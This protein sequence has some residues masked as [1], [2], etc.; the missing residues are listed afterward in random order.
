MCIDVPDQNINGW[1][2][3]SPLLVQA[4]CLL[5]PPGQK[6]PKMEKSEIG[7]KLETNVWK[8]PPAFPG[9]VF[10]AHLQLL[11]LLHRLKLR[12]KCQVNLVEQL[13]TA[14]R[15]LAAEFRPIE[16]CRDWV[17]LCIPDQPHQ[18]HCQALLPLLLLLGGRVRDVGAEDLLQEVGR[19]V[20]V[21]LWNLV[22]MF[23]LASQVW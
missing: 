7:N 18:G 12:L 14:G 2:F 15:H 9:D 23:Q 3:F 1:I 21:V 22:R 6:P 5:C 8:K 17:G 10:S 16:G 13:S 11:L 4:S 19:D 20:D